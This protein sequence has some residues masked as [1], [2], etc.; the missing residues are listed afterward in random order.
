MRH[1][2]YDITV[3]NDIKT[4]LKT[5]T[6]TSLTRQQLDRSDIIKPI[7]TLFTNTVN[8]ANRTACITQRFAHKETRH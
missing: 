1:V 6:K 7:S 8:A 3:K 2:A 5:V 4:N